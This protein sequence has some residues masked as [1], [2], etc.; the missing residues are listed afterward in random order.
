MNQSASA[1]ILSLRLLA[2][3]V[4]PPLVAPLIPSC[5]SIVAFF[6]ECETSLRDTTLVVNTLNHASYSSHPFATIELAFD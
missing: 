2:L 5:A 6:F 3:L 1:A 4:R